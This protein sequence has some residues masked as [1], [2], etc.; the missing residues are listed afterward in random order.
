[1]FQ[2]LDNSSEIS[3]DEAWHKDRSYITILS[4]AMEPL[5]L[6]KCIL[7]L[8]S[9]YSFFKDFI[10]LFM[11]DRDTEREKEIEREREREREAET[12]AE[13]EAGSMPGTRHGTRFW[14]SRITPRAKG[15]R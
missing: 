10:Y 1:M 15:R 4:S 6:N 11:R 7:S 12:Q 14:D 13:G 3:L 8:N 2:I 5:S 9:L